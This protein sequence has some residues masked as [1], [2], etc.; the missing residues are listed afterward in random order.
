MP[1]VRPSLVILMTTLL[2]GTV[3]AGCIS[4]YGPKADEPVVDP[5][6]ALS[7]PVYDLLESFNVKVTGHDGK[8]QDTWVYKP[9]TNDS[10]ATFPV[11][12]NFS[13]Y[14]TN[15]AG[16]H[17]TGGDAFS[18]YMIDYFVPR[19]YA[20]VLASV[21]GTGHSEGCFP[22]GGVAELEDAYS[23]VDHFAK[24]EWSNGKV[25]A[26][27]KSYDG[28]TIQGLVGYK[29]HEALK[30][31][32]PVSG[33]SEL[34]KYNYRNGAPYFHGT[35]FNAY[36]QLMVGGDMNPFSPAESKPKTDEPT[37]V[38][39][40]YACADTPEVQAEGI[41]SAA[42]GLYTDYWKER[43]YTQ[44]ASNIETAFFFVHGFQD[45]NV[46]PDHI[47]PWL[48]VIPEDVPVKAWLHQW[49]QDGTGHVYPMRDDWNLTMLRMMDHFLKDIDT[50]ILEEPMFQVQDS[51][52]IWR[53]E[54][55][56]PP[57]DVETLSLHPVVDGTLA[58]EPESGTHMQTARATAA[59][60]WTFEVEETLHYAGE[61][62]LRANLVTSNPNTI[63]VA[64]L[65]MEHNGTRT[66]MNEGVLRA[67]LRDSLETPSPVV[68]G[69]AYDYTIP[70]YPQDDVFP[71]GSKLILTLAQGGS[72][73]S[74]VTTDDEP[75]LTRVDLGK[76]ALEL[77]VLDV[78]GLRY[79]DPQ[80]VETVCWTC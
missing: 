77:P 34:Y 68:P 5:M 64:Q 56:W 75:V 21:R 55:S 67:S 52:G 66:W 22:I 27:G 36:Y 51:T 10:D 32:F 15:L 8:L 26:G 20:V 29:P 78:T 41:G 50:G 1:P 59:M 61:P 76:T 30:L 80:P 25:A 42:T 12:I 23:V 13:P 11:F 71:A 16:D 24:V 35:I 4:S 9:K 58:T 33:I 38:V 44:Y 74:V 19:G 60:E 63:W 43:D 72:R 14:W 49:T 31:I 79:E 18:K 46:K 47:L 28:T 53:D 70:F 7:E 48:D 73:Q 54:G 37:L 62:L 57:E 17:S 39:D 2:A 69:Q 3:V 40:D 45:W 65:W 6:A